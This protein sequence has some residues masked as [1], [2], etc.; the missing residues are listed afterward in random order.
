MLARSA[1][2][3]WWGYAE[4]DARIVGAAVAVVA[5]AALIFLARRLAETRR[6]RGRPLRGP[7]R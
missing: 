4:A 3:A 1:V 6:A 7:R 2:A 5:I